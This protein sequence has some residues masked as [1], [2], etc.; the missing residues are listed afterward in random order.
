MWAL[1]A[2]RRM[3]QGTN[4][5]Q[6]IS[7]TT[8]LIEINDI[9][10]TSWLQVS[11]GEWL[12]VV[13]AS[14]TPDLITLDVADED[15][16]Q[17][18]IETFWAEA[19]VFG[20]PF[21]KFA[22]LKYPDGS[23]DTVVKLNH[24][25]YDG[26][27][28]RIFDD[29]FGAILT[30]K[31]IPEHGQF[32][33]FAFHV[34]SSDKSASLAYWKQAMSGRKTSYLSSISSPKITAAHRSVIDTNLDTLSTST[35][36]SPSAIFQ[37]AYELWLSRTSADLDVN[38]D[39]LLSGRNVDLPNLDPMTINGT[40][41]T[42]LPIRHR[43]SEET[44]T[45][46]AFLQTTQEN[47][48][49]ITDHASIGLSEIYTAASLSRSEFGNKTLFLFQ[50]FEPAGAKDEERWL[51]LAKSKVRMYQ[52]YAL[53]V[54]VAKGLEPGKH[55]LAVMYD[56]EIFGEERGREI[57]EEIRDIVERFAVEGGEGRLLKD[58]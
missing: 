6:W 54:E 47:F 34:Y 56:G 42:F 25:V 21:I 32:K 16:A 58:V 27:L 45:L 5:N 3:P 7:A 39:Y 18:F 33:D 46:N 14:S 28:L 36:V 24:A 1:I 2:T 40:L 52:P 13:L 49:A 43:I 35:G 8:K 31:P 19:F 22:L 12:G 4:L 50:P 55:K 38:F 26:T 9:L 57:S 44:T 48:W 51:I 10:R 23:F 53:V 37:A 17:T 15:A 30:S 11:S 29:H 20:K 41:A